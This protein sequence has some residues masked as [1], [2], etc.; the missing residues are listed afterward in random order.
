[1][2]PHSSELS[3]VFH[4]CLC[5]KF[6]A[7]VFYVSDCCCSK[8]VLS[9]GLNLCL[10]LYSAFPVLL[11]ALHSLHFNYFYLPRFQ[12][13]VRITSQPNMYV[14]RLLEEIRVPDRS[15]RSH[16]NDDRGV[17]TTTPPCHP[18]LK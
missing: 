15:P 2:L 17:L 7:F 11:K 10:D 3:H 14:V 12:G 9:K 4:D 16:S 8:G 1:M 5:S 18:W 6:L 13:Q